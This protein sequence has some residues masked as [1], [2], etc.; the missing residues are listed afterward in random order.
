MNREKTT[1][2]AEKFAEEEA[3]RQQELQAYIDNRKYNVP[4]GA[5]AQRRSVIISILLTIIVLLLAIV[6]VDLMLDS[7]II[8]L[9]TK[10]P[11]THFFSLGG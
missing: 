10:L 1:E 7:G 6:L 3:K 5:V 11:H 8:L 2:E 4:I 9:L